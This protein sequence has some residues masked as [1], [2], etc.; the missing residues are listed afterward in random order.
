MRI[1]KFLSVSLGISRRKADELIDS[2]MVKVNSSIAKRGQDISHDDL[3][4]FNGATVKNEH[5]FK[6]IMLNK[7]MEYVCS[8]NGQGSKTIYS[9]LP[10]CYQDLKYAGRLDKYSTG[11]LLLT[12]DGEFI[13]KLTHPKNQKNK[14]YE[15]KLDKTFK[16]EDQIS[17]NQGIV[18][19]DGISKFNVNI[20]KDKLIATLK[21]GRNKQIRRTFNKLGYKVISLHRTT[22]GKY[23]LGSL[24]TGEYI[25]VN[26]R[27]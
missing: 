12:N 20:K 13:N 8:R 27:L 3:V 19:D 25:L 7:P 15:V 4:Y 18:L 14:I 22:F 2:N 6:Y 9:L 23:K 24:K 10:E 11:L 21:E 17:L 1:N 16:K 26:K 5:I